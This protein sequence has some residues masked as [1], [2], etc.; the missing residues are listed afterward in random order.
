MNAFKKNKAVA[1][2]VKAIQ[3]SGLLKSR[4]PHK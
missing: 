4:R 2:P 1:I 3:K